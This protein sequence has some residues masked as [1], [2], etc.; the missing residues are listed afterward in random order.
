MWPT[1]EEL[2]AAWRALL[3]DSDSAGEFAS[4]VLPPLVAALANRY[5]SADPDDVFTA[6]S[7]AFLAFIRN[8]SRFDPAVAPLPA[9]LFVIARRRLL[10]RFE[11][12]RRHREGRIPW[13]SVELE[14]PARNELE[15][16][17][18]PSFDAPELQPVI[19][20]F[21]DEERRVFDLMRDGERR[22]EVFAAVLEIAVLPVDDQAAEVKRVKDRILARL[23]RAAGGGHA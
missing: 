16:D 14:P 18:S 23:K 12:G 7:D 19:A 2:L 9:Y 10:N 6:A 15:D 11:A 21:S 1:D 3:A 8:P 20:A 13:D 22:T 17:D 5:P 4:L